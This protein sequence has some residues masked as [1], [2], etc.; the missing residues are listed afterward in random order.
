MADP[1]P[2]RQC[3]HIVLFPVDGGVAHH[4]GSG[5]ARDHAHGVAGA[6]VRPGRHVRSAGHQVAVECGGHR[7][8]TL[9]V[10]ITQQPTAVRLGPGG[11]QCVQCA[12]PGV[13]KTA[14]ARVAQI[15]RI[16][17]QRDGTPAQ[18]RRSGRWRIHRPQL[19]RPHLKEHRVEMRA[20]RQVKAVEPHHATRTRMHMFVPGP[21]RGED[22]VS[23]GH[24]AALRVD[25]GHGAGALHDKTDCLD[26]VA[27]RTR[28]LAGKQCLQPGRQ[29]GG[30]DRRA[31][32]SG[33]REQQNP[34]FGI[35]HGDFAH[36]APDQ[37]LHGN[38][39]PAPG[40]IRSRRLTARNP[41]VPVPQ[42]LGICRMQSTKQIAGSFK[43]R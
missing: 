42:R 43:R 7:A 14:V 1:V 33:V 37:R 21:G 41:A 6:S 8:A 19:R 10:D 26:R 31:L 30:G 27:V 28:R 18:G 15:K 34:A 40:R 16:W 12:L 11:A 23:L 5:T 35:L 32:E 24:E 39:G 4:A 9:A 13:A 38:P 17:P 29:V 3:E 25:A 2:V 20:K 36:G 22:Q